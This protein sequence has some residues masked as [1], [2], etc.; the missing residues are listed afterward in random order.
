MEVAFNGAGNRGEEASNGYSCPHYT[1]GLELRCATEPKFE[2][3]LY[4][5]HYQVVMNL[6]DCGYHSHILLL[7]MQHFIGFLL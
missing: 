4:R 3:L 6:D 2:M 1:E 7:L 5:R